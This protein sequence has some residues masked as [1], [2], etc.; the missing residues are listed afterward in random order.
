MIEFSLALIVYAVSYLKIFV[1]PTYM[2]QKL[3]AEF[4][5]RAP[6]AEIKAS[7]E[8]ALLYV[9]ELRRQKEANLAS[10]RPCF[11]PS[12]FY[13]PFYACVESTGYETEVQVSATEVKNSPAIMVEDP[14]IYDDADEEEEQRRYEEQVAR[15]AKVHHDYSASVQD[16]PPPPPPVAVLVDVVPKKLGAPKTQ[17][18]PKN[19]AQPNGKAP[20]APKGQIPPKNNQTPPPKVQALPP[21]IQVAAN[22]IPDARPLTLQVRPAAREEY[23]YNMGDD[24]MSDAMMMM[25]DAGDCGEAMG[26]D[27]GA[28]MGGRQ[29]MG[30]PYIYD[31]AE[32]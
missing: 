5:D 11:K 3:T 27:M 30:G 22:P 13:Q 15:Q 2:E 12:R 26:A 18:A 28:D 6:G 20:P 1:D 29:T 23:S 8:A 7:E 14:D 4:Q 24:Y 16:S 19:K 25:M 10:G 21:T 31:Y 32:E 17:D 9:N